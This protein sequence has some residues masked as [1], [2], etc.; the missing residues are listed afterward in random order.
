M[1]RVDPVTFAVVQKKLI[2]IANGMQE[3]AVRA[4]VTTFMYEIMD[5]LFAL[6]DAE[7]GVIAESKG[8]FLASLSPAVKNCLDYIGRENI[9]PGD[10]VV[11][12][13]PEI[14]GNHTSDAVLFTP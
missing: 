13:V 5:C 10:M 12:N 2:S 3:I 7:A 11:S 6:R 8:L 14:T 9:E 4:G 1:P